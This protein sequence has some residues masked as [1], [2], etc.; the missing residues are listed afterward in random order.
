MGRQVNEAGGFICLYR[1]YME[2]WTWYTQTGQPA[3]P[4]EAWLDLLF[5]ANFKD[6]K[7]YDRGELLVIR[8]G[9]ILTGERALSELWKWS[10]SKVRSFLANLQDDGSITV[11]RDQRR[12]VLTVC[13][14]DKWQGKR[15]TDR[16]TERPQTGPQK[17]PSNKGN[18]GNKETNTLE[19]DRFWQAYPKKEAKKAAERAWKQ[20][21]PPIEAV[22]KALEWQR[23]SP[24][25]TKDG[26]Q[27]I[28]NPASYINAGRWDD[29]PVVEVAAPEI[30]YHSAAD[31]IAEWER[32][33]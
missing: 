25:W 20:R 4:S 2:H 16:T 5:K 7:R 11:N 29:E 6:S 24:N 27:F 19:F 3:A 17:D 8:R 1:S 26:G 14:Y 9:Q 31:T 13:E 21:R 28:P 12:A 22:L 23:Q 33:A 15:T 32:D 30:K 18:K 10:R